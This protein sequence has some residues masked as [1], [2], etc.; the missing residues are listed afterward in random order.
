[1]CEH[2]LKQTTNAK[3]L[4]KQ[5]N[6][7]LVLTGKHEINESKARKLSARFWLSIDAFIQRIART[8]ATKFLR[9][10]AV[11]TRSP[12][13]HVRTG[14]PVDDIAD[15]TRILTLNSQL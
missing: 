9:L 3:F 5:G 12:N 6:A 10:T 15:L 14:K 2:G 13:S 7:F 1:M 11:D 8:K 4:G